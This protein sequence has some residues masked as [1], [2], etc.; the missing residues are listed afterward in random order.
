MPTLSGFTRPSDSINAIDIAAVT[1]MGFVWATAPSPTLANNVV[2]DAG[3]SLGAYADTLS[4]LPSST[5][6]YY[7]AY[8][9]N[10]AGT[11]YGSDQTFTTSASVFASSSNLLLLGV[12]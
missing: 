12:G 10:A 8:A 5:L 2:N 7:A 3:T 11:S 4:G 9:T 6:I 1:V